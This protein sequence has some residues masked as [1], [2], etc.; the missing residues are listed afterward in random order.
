MHIM[1]MQ[2]AS[3]AAT[4]QQQQQA[5]WPPARGLAA[6]GPRAARATARAATAAGGLAAGLRPGGDGSARL[7]STQ[8]F[9]GPTGNFNL[10]FVFIFGRATAIFREFFLF[11]ELKIK[12]RN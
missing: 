10:Y 2:G 1:H 4:M 8:I 6:R 3:C 11:F 5:A 7:A 12:K 9:F